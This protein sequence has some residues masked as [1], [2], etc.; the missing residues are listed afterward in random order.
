MIK[1]IYV[2]G[3]I[4]PDTISRLSEAGANAFVGGSSGLFKKNSTLLDNYKKLRK[5]SS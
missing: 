5:A 1:D 4:N 2:D 3:H